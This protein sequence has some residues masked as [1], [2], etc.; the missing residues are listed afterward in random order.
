M[1]NNKQSQAY[2]G[3]HFRITWLGAVDW[4]RRHVFNRWITILVILLPAWLVHA[5]YQWEEFAT[6]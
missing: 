5:N 4:R 1:E 2:D 6:V 3:V